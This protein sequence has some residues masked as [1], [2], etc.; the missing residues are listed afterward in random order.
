M[1]A[2]IP[3]SGTIDISG[4]ARIL[5]VR[6]DVGDRR[7]FLY[8]PPLI[9]LRPSVQPGDHGWWRPTRV[10]DQGM[11]PGPFLHGPCAGLDRRPSAGA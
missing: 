9:P 10:R 5:D 2:G 6:V 1:G 8:S 4:T 11:D 7:D 3:G